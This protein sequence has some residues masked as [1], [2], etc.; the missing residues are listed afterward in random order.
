VAA[1]QDAVRADRADG[2]P[3]TPQRSVTPRSLRTAHLTTLDLRL[4]TDKPTYAVG[5]PVTLQLEATNQ[6]DQQRTLAFPTSQECDFVVSAA[7]GA[8]VWQA[9]CNRFFLQAFHNRSI[10]PGETLDFTA[11]WDQL[12]CVPASPNQAQPVPPDRYSAL[13][14]LTTFPAALESASVEFTIE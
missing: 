5:E 8:V 1:P 14:R 9:S 6:S 4:D 10:G 7:A 2:V 11:R 12:T 3:S 13:A